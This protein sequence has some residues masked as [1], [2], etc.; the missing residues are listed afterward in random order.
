MITA[1]LPRF[2]NS[3]SKQEL[4]TFP[5]GTKIDMIEGIRP[6]RAQILKFNPPGTVH[7]YQLSDLT[8]EGLAQ[9]TLKQIDCVGNDNDD[10]D[11]ETWFEACED[12]HCP[13]SWKECN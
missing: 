12:V 6:F 5:I 10:G 7:R 1:S 13:N 8:T 9:Y 11:C 3:I 4:T 2:I